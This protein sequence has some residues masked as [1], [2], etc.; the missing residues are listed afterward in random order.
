MAKVLL[1]G[2]AVFIGFHLTQHLLSKNYE[3]IGIDEINDY[4][5]TNLKLDRLKELGI[6]NPELNIFVG[7]ENSNFIF[8]KGC[9]DNRQ[10]IE[11]IFEE[12]KFDYVI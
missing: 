11:T 4:Y 5:D 12:H 2:S 7:S 1:T 9:T 6:N 10:L 3:V 8:C